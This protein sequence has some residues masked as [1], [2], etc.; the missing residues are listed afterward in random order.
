MLTDWTKQESQLRRLTTQAGRYLSTFRWLWL[1]NLAVAAIGLATHQ[2]ALMAIA[3]GSSFVA[4]IGVAF[5]RRGR[6]TVSEATTESHRIQQKLELP[7]D[8]D[9]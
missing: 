6:T 7:I 9:S 4:L 5:A 3:A 2:Y 1:L 8:S